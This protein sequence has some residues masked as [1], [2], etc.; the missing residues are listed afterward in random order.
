MA[1]LKFSNEDIGGEI[2]VLNILTMD[3]LSTEIANLMVG[4]DM[5]HNTR[6]HVWVVLENSVKITFLVDK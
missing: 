2:I 5:I 3:I 4:H 6:I 1:I